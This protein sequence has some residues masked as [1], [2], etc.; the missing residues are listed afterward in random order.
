MF[1]LLRVLRKSIPL[2]A[3]QRLTWIL[4]LVLCIIAYGT[5]GFHFIEG[6]PWTVSFYWTFVTIGTVGYG[7]YSPKTT[8]GMF[9]AISLIIL[10]IGTFALAIESLVNLIFKR[11]QMKFMG[12]INVERSKHVV[13]C[14]WTESTVECIKEIGKESE[15]FVLDEDE[16]VRK[17]ALKNGANFVHG[18]PTRIKDLEKANVKGAQAVIVDMD[19][20]SKTIH[21]ILSV[22]KLDQDVRVVA[23][24]QRYENIEQIKLAGANQVISP[25]VIS[26]RLMYKSIDDGY[27]AMFVQDVLAEHTSRE[28]REVKISSESQF[29]GLSLLEADIHERT[30]IVVVGVGRDGDLVIDPPRNY[31]LETGDVVLGIGKV[32]EFE[33]LE[34]MKVT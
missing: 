19:S 26:G 8:L 16:E 28:M 11:Q 24:A 12:L 18:D 15:V 2:V 22:R 27:E 5:L 32:E 34:N 31:T 23:E 1:V 17:N 9:F 6:Q 20:D 7:D 29:N 10:G 13:I 14:G 4:I 21:C 25:F 3:K 30:G 33:K